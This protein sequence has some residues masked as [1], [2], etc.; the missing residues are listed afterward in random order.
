[1]THVMHGRP[2][3]IPASAQTR[4]HGTPVL[5]KFCQA[6]LAKFLAH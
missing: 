5:A 1:M 4:G 6:Q 3:L 2:Y